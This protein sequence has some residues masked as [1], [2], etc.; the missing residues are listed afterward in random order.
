MNFNWAGDIIFRDTILPNKR[1]VIGS[2]Q[3]AIPTDIREWLRGVDSLVISNA[4]RQVPGLPDTHGPGDFNRRAHQIW[5]YVAARIRYVYDMQ[6]EGYGDFWLFPDE[7]LSLGEGDCEDCAILLAAMMVASGISPFCVRVVMGHLY[8]GPQLLGAHAWVV[9][10]G[11]GGHWRLLESTLDE[12]PPILPDAEK[13]AQPQALRWYHPVF[14]FNDQH[15]WWIRQPAAPQLPPPPGLDDFLRRRREQ[16]VRYVN[17]TS[18]FRQH[19]LAYTAQVAS[20]PMH[21][22]PGVRR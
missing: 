8:Q 18:P 19:L 11:E 4:L 10:Q 7:T 17:L 14:C 12:V 3:L 5:A 6:R 22:P 16:G 20:T 9:Y 15:L 21:P 1:F 2:P 13:L